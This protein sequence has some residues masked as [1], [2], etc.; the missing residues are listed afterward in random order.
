MILRSIASENISY[1]KVW[2]LFS[3]LLL[4]VYGLKIHEKADNLEIHLSRCLG[5]NLEGLC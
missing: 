2:E 5:H 4:E 3:L 1:I